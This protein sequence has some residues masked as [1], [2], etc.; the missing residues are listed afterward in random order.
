M[1]RRT[2]L[3]R[4]SIGLSALVAG[5]AGIKGISGSGPGAGRVYGVPES[6]RPRTPLQHDLLRLGLSRTDVPPEAWRD[7]AALSLL[8]QDVFD[9]PEVASAFNRDPQG[10][11]KA[12][13]LDDVR[14]DTEAVEVK[15]ALALGDPDVRSA[16][17]RDDPRAFVQALEG[18]GL[19]RS[20]EPS[21][22][23]QRIGAQLDGLKGRVDTDPVPES[24][25]VLAICL[26]AVWV[27]V[28][29]IQD[30]VV[31][32]AVAAVV[33]LY[34]YALIST[35]AYGGGGGGRRRKKARLSTSLDHNPSFRLAG[36][37]GGPDFGDRVA[38]SFVEE[39]VERI[40]SAVET[41]DAYQKA[42]VLPPERLRALVRSQMLR[43]LQGNAVDLEAPRS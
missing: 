43:Q 22:L 16:I 12:V 41:L 35:S 8:A 26:A 18:R 6:V 13:G 42:G 15:V 29:V 36:A 3:K 14:L 34:A 31:A 1:K 33:S 17:D 30:A 27:W 19:I 40:A 9:N 7:V 25:T 4:S 11:L 5:V 23:A 10:Y 24:C 2:F 38:E 32:V 21:Q 39:N 20:P 28:A 37:L